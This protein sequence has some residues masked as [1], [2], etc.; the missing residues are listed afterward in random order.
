MPNDP[1]PTRAEVEALLPCPFCGGAAQY[2]AASMAVYCETEG[3]TGQCPLQAE[4]AAIK[5]WNRRATL[6][7]AAPGAE[8]KPD[9][10]TSREINMLSDRVR[11]YIA[12]LE[13]ECDPSGTIRENFRLREENAGLRALDKERTEG[14]PDFNEALKR[15]W[16][17]DWSE[18]KDELERI[19]TAARAAVEGEIVKAKEQTHYANGVA[20]TNINRAD[21]AEAEIERLVGD[22]EKGVPHETILRWHRDRRTTIGDKS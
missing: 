7:Q 17:G 16:D 3:C 13:T 11:R 14:K 10:V 6:P 4:S 15:I 8:D 2:D 5:A 22:L 1:T 20:E 21:E 18:G 19:W 9:E 12:A